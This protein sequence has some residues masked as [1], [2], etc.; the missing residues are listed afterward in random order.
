[1]GRVKDIN[2]I[3]NL[4]ILL[5]KEGFE[6]VKLSYLGGLW[7]LIEL[8]N[9]GSKQKFLDHV[10]V[11]SWFCTLLNAYNDF[12]SD[13]RVV[14]VDI[15]V[16]L[17]FTFGLEKRLPRLV[18][19]WGE[20]FGYRGID[21]WLL[22]CSKRL[23]ASLTNNQNYIGEIQGD[24]LKARCLWLGAKELFTIEIP[25]FLEPKSDSLGNSG[26]SNLCILGRLLS[27]KKDNDL[28]S[29]DKDLE[30]G[31]V[32]DDILLNRMDLNRRLQDIKLLEVKDLVQKSKIKWAI[33]GD[34]NSKFF[35]CNRVNER[36]Q[37]LMLLF[38]IDYLRSVDELIR[39][40]IEGTEFRRAVW[41]LWRE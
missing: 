33:E 14:W 10:G 25:I 19:K 30:R 21:F 23:C 20:A 9:E 2:S 7:V 28:I 24:F 4:R 15:E 39:A 34:E 6:H 22:F 36:T 27:S 13:E 29:I 8:D 11:N 32:S 38:Q 40:V 12:V 5:A 37:N 3:P 18:N 1:M 35:S 16:S 26:R 41:Q 17:S 31:N